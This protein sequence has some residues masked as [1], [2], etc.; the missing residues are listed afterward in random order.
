MVVVGAVVVVPDAVMIGLV[1]RVVVVIAVVLVTVV[2]G[3]TVID[4][5][6]V[7]EGCLVVSA[8][9]VFW[10]VAAGVVA[11]LCLELSWPQEQHSR[12]RALPPIWRKG[13]PSL[14]LQGE[15]HTR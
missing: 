8:G 9:L 7:A 5:F 12:H 6:C 14:G 4:G 13:G 10:V 11:T 15:I 1:R 3:R 2:L